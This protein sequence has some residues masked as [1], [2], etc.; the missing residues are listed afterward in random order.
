MK[1]IKSSRNFFMLL[2]LCYAAFFL[3]VGAY[4]YTNRKQKH[5]SLPATDRDFPAWA[6]S[7]SMQGKF[8]TRYIDTLTCDTM[9]FVCRY[10][11][12]GDTIP[13]LVRITYPNDSVME[14]RYYLDNNG[15]TVLQDYFQPAMLTYLPTDSATRMAD[16]LYRITKDSVMAEE[17]EELI[18]DLS[19][20]L[21]RIN[22]QDTD[23]I[24]Q[25]LTDLTE[26][27]MTEEKMAHETN[28]TETRRIF[29][30]V[31]PDS[32]ASKKINY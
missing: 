10:D 19:A 31:M 11:E 1:K 21:E 3:V 26:E 5:P 15:D 6:D 30:S 7:T 14:F 12:N 29:N 18:N 9:Y 23:S 27:T 22:R 28:R 24:E 25:V 4:V 13:D 17:S 32:T 20:F 2:L 16:S 8:F